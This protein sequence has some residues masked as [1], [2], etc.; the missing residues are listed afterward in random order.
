MR[1]WTLISLGDD[2]QY[3]GNTG[4]R[5][6]LS[7]TYRYD[8]TVPNHKQLSVGDLVFIRNRS[9]LLGIAVIENVISDP[10]S[11]VRQ[12]CPECGTVNIKRRRRIDPPWRCVNAHT[13]AEPSVDSVPVTAYEANYGG[14]YVQAPSGFTASRLRAA[15]L[16]PNDQLAIEEVDA[17]RLERELISAEPKLAELFAA[18]EQTNVPSPL[19]AL[20]EPADSNQESFTLS[21]HDT[22]EAILRAIKVRRGQRRFRDSLI[23]RYGPRCMVSGCE[24]LDIIEAAHI[25]PYRGEETNHAENGLLLRADLH[26]LFDLNLLGVEPD[27]FAIQLHPDAL[28]A[29]YGQFN[30]KILITRGTKRPA[31]APLRFRWETFQRRLRANDPAKG[32]EA[33]T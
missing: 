26:T 22:R 32:Y 8:S 12:R 5:D 28:A 23:R 13:F 20:S 21:T 11:N 18:S 2:R 16:R 15:A 17:S 24:L 3:G 33:T 31:A 29:G 10:A 9:R 25:W 1:A 27:S 19:E 7:R 30:G 14:T 4:Y 6:D